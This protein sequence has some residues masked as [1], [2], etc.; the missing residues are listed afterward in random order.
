[1]AENINFKTTVGRIMNLCSRREM[2]VSDVKEKLQGW[3]LSEAETTKALETLISEKF[4]DNARYSKAFARDKF[5]YNRWGRIKIAANLRL[6]KVE[7]PDIKEALKSIDEDEY[8]SVLKKLLELQRRK[9]KA[10][11]QFDL[12]GKLL[13]F[14]LSKG[15]ESELLYD[16]LNEEF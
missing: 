14:G 15:F 8:I 5:R 3:G 12:K 7:A 16:I 9:I 2:C 13:R 6:K 4:I 10:K 11:N 1:M